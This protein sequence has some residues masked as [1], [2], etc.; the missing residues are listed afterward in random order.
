MIGTL[1]KPN[2]KFELVVVNRFD[3]GALIKLLAEVD[4]GS[5]V[6]EWLGARTKTQGATKSSVLHDDY[7]AWCSM[8]GLVALGTKSFSQS[9]IAAGVVKLK[10][11][12]EGERFELE[13]LN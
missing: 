1:L 11:S 3:R 10:R 4:Q 5:N 7:S 8:A 6:E 2:P 12:R 9:L 13:L